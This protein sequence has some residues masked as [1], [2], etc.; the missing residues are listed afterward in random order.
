MP[1]TVSLAG[2]G[3]SR[4][5]TTILRDADLAVEAGEV[6][7]VTG[8]NGTGKTTLLRVAATL[9]IPRSGT[10]AVLGATVGTP[11]AR[12]VRP[13]IGMVGHRPA[14][15]P[16]LTVAEQLAVW[17]DLADID[18]S[19]VGRALTAVGLAA[20][21]DRRGTELSAG[22]ARRADLARIV[23][24]RPDLLLLDEP[25]AGLDADATP[26]VD[27]LC[28]AATS[29]GGSAMVVRHDPA[30]VAR[31]CDRMVRIVEGPLAAA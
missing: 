15:A 28:R 22:M 26:I 3:V 7:G 27:A 13:R 21:A 5:G 10:A 1:P 20:A 9:L 6:V 19:E 23:L 25:D 16:H 4:G 14:G 11:A 18:R 12:A 31:L 30:R 2:V 17:A 8:P 29:R 24:Q